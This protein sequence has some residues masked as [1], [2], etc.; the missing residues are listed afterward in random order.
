MSLRYGERAR[1][2]EPVG[3]AGRRQEGGGAIKV[4]EEEF[5]APG[6]WTWP[7]KC[8]AV[9]VFIVGGGGGGGARATQPDDYAIN[10]GGGGVATFT[11]PV[12][13]P[14]PVTVG[15]GG[16]GATPTS[17]GPIGAVGGTSSFGPTASVGGGQGGVHS[18]APQ[19]P[20]VPASLAPSAIGGSACGGTRGVAGNYGSDA[21]APQFPT[22]GTQVA[23]SGGAGGMLKAGLAG[24]SR[25]G[26]GGGTAPSGLGSSG[27]AVG[28]LSIPVLD[29]TGQG[30]AAGVGWPTN[31][32][33]QS[34]SPGIVIVR[35]IEQ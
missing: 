24:T 7:G 32:P 2:G 19:A 26:Y 14:V 23:A 22:A 17:P 35:W 1:S 11:V 16:A 10:G 5:L 31:G 33:A 34:G 25:Y 28:T 15:A 12:S 6:T 3:N 27:R 13:G 8:S 9:E 30:G 20:F 21:Y 29:N 18:D 4:Y